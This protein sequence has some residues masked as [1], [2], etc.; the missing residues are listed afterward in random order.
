MLRIFE[1]VLYAEN[2]DECMTFYKDFLGLALISYNPE[3]SIFLKCATGVLIIFRASKTLI[4]DAG[5]PPH[6][7]KGPGHLAFTTSHQELLEW[8]KKLER[9]GV[10]II[11]HQKWENGA[12]SLYFHDPA[13]N[14]LEI[15]TPDLWG[16]PE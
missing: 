3:R 16:F 8:Q 4:P 10:E 5:V 12:Q 9:S 11:Q 1:T 7:T 15:V 6:G 2:L 14:I 13:G